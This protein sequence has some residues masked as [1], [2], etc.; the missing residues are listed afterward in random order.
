MQLSWKATQHLPRYCK[1]AVLYAGD[2]F[3]IYHILRISESEGSEPTV[4]ITYS[5]PIAIN[6][7]NTP[8]IALL[9]Y[10]MLSTDQSHSSLAT[11]LGVTTPEGTRIVDET[12]TE[13]ESNRRSEEESNRRS[14]ET[15]VSMLT[16]GGKSTDNYIGVVTLPGKPIVPPPAE[17]KD[18]PA[19]DKDS[20]PPPGPAPINLVW[21]QLEATGEIYSTG[22]TSKE[23]IAQTNSY[24]AFLLQARPDL[25]S[26]TGILHDP[27]KRT[28]RL[29]FMDA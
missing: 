13:E 20:P 12:E 7:T 24:T 10:M 14:E 11:T 27:K 19:E 16:N 3:L 9:V 8:Y 4:I 22:S 15:V 21:S 28:F 23:A 26:V 29:F 18:S 5:D 2:Q 17:D 6:D 1:W 25:V